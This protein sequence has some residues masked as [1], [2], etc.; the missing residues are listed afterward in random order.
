MILAV[1]L[2]LLQVAAAA[3]PPADPPASVSVRIIP[4]TP[5]PVEPL[6]CKSSVVTG[7]LIAKRKQC[8][9]RAQWRYVDDVQRQQNQ[10]LLDNQRT[11]QGCG[12]PAC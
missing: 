11:K 4:A 9:T 7:S 2:A 3:S 8:L 10:E 6:I 1:G 12:G 5:V